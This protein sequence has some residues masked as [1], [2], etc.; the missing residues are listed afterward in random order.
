VGKPLLQGFSMTPGYPK[1][2]IG[3]AKFDLNKFSN[4]LSLFSQATQNVIGK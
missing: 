4:N 3:K 2:Y 1:F